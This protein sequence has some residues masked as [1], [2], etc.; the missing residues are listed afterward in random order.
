MK[1][2]IKDVV[3][4]TGSILGG[5]QFGGIK[6]TTIADLTA[7]MLDEGTTKHTKV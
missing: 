3:T 6:N 4:L 1:T 5:T 7:D 2:P